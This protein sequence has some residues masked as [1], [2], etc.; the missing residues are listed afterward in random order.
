M[1]CC[2]ICGL[3]IG[4][5]RDP[6]ALRKSL[7]HVVPKKFGGEFLP[8][9]LKWAHRWCNSRRGHG[10]LTPEL[11]AECKAKIGAL[12]K[13]IRKRRQVLS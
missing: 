13:G 12:N 8:G 9:N 3:G 6:D 10:D 2:W 4:N 11:V 5:K 7:D 1:T